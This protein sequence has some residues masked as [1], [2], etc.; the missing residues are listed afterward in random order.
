MQVPVGIGPRAQLL[1]GDFRARLQTVSFDTGLKHVTGMPSKGM[2]SLS[3]GQESTSQRMSLILS[4]KNLQNASESS[5]REM[6][7][8][9]TGTAELPMS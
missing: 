8:G 1:V 9:R 5:R 7:V 3:I 6:S 4:E 2:K